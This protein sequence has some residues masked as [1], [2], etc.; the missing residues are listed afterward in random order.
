MGNALR[1]SGAYELK[2]AWRPGPHG[3]VICIATTIAASEPEHEQKG[4][5]Q[6]A[7]G[8]HQLFE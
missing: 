2:I 8:D 3:G 1:A 4:N 7:T 5:E 6:G